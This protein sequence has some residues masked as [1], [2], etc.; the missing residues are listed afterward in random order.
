M[1]SRSGGLCA[2]KAGQQMFFSNIYSVRSQC[3]ILCWERIS[4][5]GQC[6]AAV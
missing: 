2:W 3:L 6:N 4:F 1:E 5:H